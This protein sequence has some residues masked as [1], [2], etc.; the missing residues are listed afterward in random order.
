[1]T[2]R[3]LLV[4]SGL[5]L[6]LSPRAHATHALGGQ[7]TYEFVGNEYTPLRPN[8]YRITCRFARD[9]SGANAPTQ[10][11]LNCRVGSPQT[12]CGST[13]ARD[14]T[15]TLVRTSLLMST[16]YCASIGNVCT[17]NGRPNYETATYE[18]T[19]T[20]PPAPAWTLSVL[21]QNRPELANIV[22][23][24]GLYLE[25]TLNNQLTLPNGT[26]RT[27]INNS[28][29][30]L[31]QQ[32][33]VS[34]VCGQMQNTVSFGA[35]EPDGDSLVYSLDRPL[36]DCNQPATYRPVHLP[37]EPPVLP[38]PCVVVPPPQSFFTPTFPLPSY[39]VTGTCPIL[40][41]DTWFP[42]DARRGTFTFKVD[43]ASAYAPNNKYV[44]VG[45]VTEYRKINNRYYLIG[46]TRR[47]LVVV[48]IDC[49]S[50]QRPN[51]PSLVA[52]QP[53][54]PTDS[55]VVE[56]PIL[57]TNIVD[58]HFSDP[59]A[60]DLL[61]VWVGLPSIL[62]LPF[63]YMN[64]D[65]AAP[66]VPVSILANGTTAPMLRVRL[67]PNPAN[68]GVTYYLPVRVEDNAC[69]IK[70]AQDFVLVLRALPKLT[71]ATS[72]GRPRS[73]FSAYP[74]PFAGQVSFLL[75]RPRPGQEVQVYDQLGRVVARLPI[76]AGAG[77]EVRLSWTPAPTLPAGVYTARATGGGPTVR[78]MRVLP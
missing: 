42:F 76:P 4:L 37:Y 28:P 53:G 39:A 66:N 47:E 74:N 41:A 51:P 48:V 15:A 17:T 12:A 75:P 59:N 24:S 61:T 34:I 73:L 29:Q 50:N 68:A 13:D 20:L 58:L 25:T 5:L 70:V 21:E 26:T 3:I 14:F 11:T 60:N 71:T 2:H 1:M 77:P 23:N 6:L 54:P 44:V 16:P 30:Y 32:E 38:A 31:A 35:T 40:R 7:L 36:A 56:T 69:P 55:L 33:L 65:P 62:S 27:I 18:A 63:A 45:K 78:L 72:A 43:S 9:C 49:G 46:S 64:D 22:G 57:T 52:G 67:H 10:L 19:V 8:F